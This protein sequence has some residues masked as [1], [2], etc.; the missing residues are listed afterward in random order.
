[1]SYTGK[2]EKQAI[3]GKCQSNS[4]SYQYT[5]EDVTILEKNDA[6]SVEDE[7]IVDVKNSYGKGH[8][9][10]TGGTSSLDIVRSVVQVVIGV[11]LF[12]FIIR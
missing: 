1:M 10:G 2:L 11:I 8:G 6:S 4:C 7:E 5:T 3:R 9:R 12:A